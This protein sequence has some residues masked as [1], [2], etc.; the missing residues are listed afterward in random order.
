MI[1]SLI[2]G[3]VAVS[4][5]PQSAEWE[6][7]AVSPSITVRLP[8]GATPMAIY[9]PMAEGQQSWSF[10]DAACVFTVSTHKLT[11]AELDK[12]PADEFLAVKAFDGFKDLFSAKIKQERDVLYHGWPGLDMVLDNGNGSA[13]EYRMF[14][15]GTTFYML[16]ETYTVGR[17]RPADV[18]RFLSS[19]AITPNPPKGPL[20]APGPVF[21]PILPDQAD[22]MIG[23]P[24]TV[25]AL[26]YKNKETGEEQVQ[27]YR[28]FY[29]DRC[30]TIEFFAAGATE[31]E[32]DIRDKVMRSFLH[33]RG[34]SSRPRQ[35]IKRD[36]IT[37]L[38]STF[39]AEEPFDGRVDIAVANGLVY[40]IS[41]EYANGHEGSKDIESFFGSFHLVSP[42]PL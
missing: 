33:A 11:K 41:M 29:G 12:T 7:V 38:T 39:A 15:V 1:T 25:K 10:S 8:R 32:A 40:V 31:S 13:N 14:V 24:G 19:L 27:G 4:T 9:Q 17:G 26:T 36:G 22:C 16:M 18:G 42:E 6:P 28:G 34:S 37:F 20:T 21:K 2:V 35:T 3:I 23:M 5:P 30:Y